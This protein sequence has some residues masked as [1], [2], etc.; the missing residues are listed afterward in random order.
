MTQPL[1]IISTLRSYEA[2]VT[3][4][5]DDLSGQNCIADDL[6]SIKLLEEQ[7]TLALKEGTVSELL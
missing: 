7:L 2:L 1:S 6:N 5:I 3:Q 4:V